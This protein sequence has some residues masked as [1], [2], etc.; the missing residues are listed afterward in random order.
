MRLDGFIMPLE[1][2]VR[3]DGN[4]LRHAL[5]V[6]IPV[7]FLLDLFKLWIRNS[8]KFYHFL[9]IR[10]IILLLLRYLRLPCMFCRLFLFSE[11]HSRCMLHHRNETTDRE[12]A[13]CW[14]VLRQLFNRNHRY[15]RR[16]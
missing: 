14:N 16:E 15:R 13:R 1:D 8:N 10:K 7:L 11:F 9:F 4:S 3:L 5:A 6:L 12:V 2:N